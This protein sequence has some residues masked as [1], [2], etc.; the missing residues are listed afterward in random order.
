MVRAEA[1]KA[2]FGQKLITNNLRGLVAEVIVASALTPNWTWC[3]ADWAGWDFVHPSGLKLEVKQSAARQTWTRPGTGPSACR[4]DIKPRT[5]SYVG[6]DWHPRLGRQADVYVFAHH[7]E[8]GAS[9]DH[10]EPS[11]W[12]FFVVAE[13]HLP[14]ASLT[15]G[16]RNVDKLAQARRLDELAGAVRDCVRLHHGGV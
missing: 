4:F 15:I 12:Q 7:F 6:A 8:I 2:A 13:K 3:S 9:A 16:L 1:S 5:G 11:Q 14:T 10:C